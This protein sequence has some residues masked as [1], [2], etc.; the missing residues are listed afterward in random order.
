LPIGARA[1]VNPA[2]ALRST[3]KSAPVETAGSARRA[4]A[5]VV[6]LCT[7]RGLSSFSRRGDRRPRRHRGDD[8]G[9]RSR[10]RLLGLAH[11]PQEGLLLLTDLREPRTVE[12]YLCLVLALREETPDGLSQRLSRQG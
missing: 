5:G 9:R 12:R 1:C 6:R 2:P 4:R 3:R 11:L 10:R 8:P 7:L